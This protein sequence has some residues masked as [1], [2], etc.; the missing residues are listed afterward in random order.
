[1]FNGALNNKS[2]WE[3]SSELLVMCVPIVINLFRYENVSNYWARYFQEWTSA[4]AYPLTLIFFCFQ[5][6]DLPYYRGMLVFTRVEMIFESG[7]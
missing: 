7:N 6:H 1:M 2:I 3:D 5:P 4:I